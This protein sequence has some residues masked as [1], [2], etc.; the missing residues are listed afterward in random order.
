MD[1]SITRDEQALVA[2]INGRIDG[3]TAREFE[4][5]MMAAISDENRVVICDLTSV[6][7]VSSAGLRVI[8]LIAK[9]LAK[10]NSVFS[11]CGLNGSV[12]EVF[13][14]SGFNKIIQVYENQEAAQADASA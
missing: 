11:V 7:Y 5:A 13:R 4:D 6:A 14:L 12:A 3:S 2:E 1:L 10:R 8:L 9:R